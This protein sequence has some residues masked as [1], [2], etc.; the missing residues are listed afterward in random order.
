VRSTAAALALDPRLLANLV[1]R[2][3]ELL[4]VRPR[5][6]AL[7]ACSFCELPALALDPR[8]LANLSSPSCSR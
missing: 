8:L 2:Q 3:P 7:H 4:E 5:R 6:I 1:A